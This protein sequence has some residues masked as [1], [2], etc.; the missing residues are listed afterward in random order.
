MARSTF[1]IPFILFLG[2][3]SFSFAG[4]TGAISGAVTDA[5]SGVP[6]PNANIVLNGTG[7]GAVTDPSGRFVIS[8][9]PVGS[10]SVQIQ[11]IGYA[12]QQRAVTIDA[13]K[14]APLNV[15]LQA[16][17]VQFREVLITA[18]RERA[19]ISDVPVASQV[20][21]RDQIERA[22]AQNI[23]ELLESYTGLLVKNNGYLG[24][25]KTASI[26]GANDNQILILLDGQRLNQAQ[27]L[28][29]DLS[30]I[31]LQTIE[32]V[33][34]IRGGHS[35]LYGTDAVGGVINLITRSSESE[36]IS[37]RIKSSVGSF[38]TRAVE[39]NVGQQFGPLDYLI[40]HNYTE[41]DGDFKF[42]SAGQ[43]IERVNNA[44]RWHDSF[45]KLGYRLSP[46]GKLNGHLQFHDADR[47]APGPLTFGPPSETATQKD[48]SLKSQLNYS[49]T[50]SQSLNLRAQA[51]FST[52]KQNYDNPDFAIH[53][54]HENDAYGLS[55][56]GNLRLPA[57]NE[58]T[59][60]YEVRGDK[61]NST[62]V[63]SKRRIIH[64][65]FVQD[66]LR[67][68]LTTRASNLQIKLV[69][70][71]RF[72]KFEDTPEPSQ[73]EDAQFS[74]KIGFL[75]NYVSD[76]QFV[77]RGNWGRSYRLPSF[78]DLYWPE[79]PFSVGNPNLLP[80]K[81]LG[82][83]VGALV[84]FK[85]AGFWTFELNYFDTQLENLILWGPRP[86]GI[87]SPDN[88]QEA[89]IA[90]VETRATFQDLGGMVNLS[91]DYNYL[92][93]VDAS[94]DPS[95][96][97]NQLIYRPKHKVDL[98]LGLNFGRLGV[99]G[100]WRFIGKRFTNAGNSLSLGSYYQTDIGASW[101]QPLL[102][103]RLRFQFDV[104]NLFEEQTPIIDGFPMP[105]REYRTSVGFD[106]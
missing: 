31:P 5:H 51:Y 99:N 81:G 40:A 42:D 103:Q 85:V 94:G 7:F 10:Y 66:Q 4:D 78:N 104:K 34:I 52:T 46:L 37:G 105:G 61:I 11:L 45:V 56:Q 74:P 18:T 70:A 91:A 77:L 3:I 27:G 89:E 41:G 72:D 63:G 33:E 106:F 64:S 87:F 90:G 32:R 49:Q 55:A 84:N 82:Y 2:L 83:D 101:S 50:V 47:G 69:P 73:A 36:S 39:A 62:D 21:S 1:L 76:I 80:E 12:P 68:P 23:G 57:D 59:T 54:V 102:G 29:P 97:G 71:L 96:D 6:I 44:V 48:R 22:S 60:G 75:A 26:R 95:L 20:I 86:D 14:N 16:R 53:S 67:L 17:A 15:T 25:L 19:L 28:A 9:V 24:S 35:A 100:S 92:N 93:A 58:L 30:D 8:N 43:R 88:V 79:D 98:N 65:L 38:G 13:G